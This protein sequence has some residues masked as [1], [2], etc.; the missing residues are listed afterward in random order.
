MS[1]YR[2]DIKKYTKEVVFQALMYTL[3]FFAVWHQP[4]VT[5]VANRDRG[6]P[7]ALNGAKE[8]AHLVFRPL[9]GFF[10]AIIFIHQ[11]VRNFRREDASLSFYEAL[12]IVFDREVEDPEHIVSN[13][14]L[15]K[16]DVA[17]GRLVFAFDDSSSS[18]DDDEDCLPEAIEM[19]DS[20]DGGRAF[21]CLQD[22]SVEESFRNLDGFS[23]DLSFGQDSV[24][25]D[26]SHHQLILIS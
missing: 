24:R 26:T 2:S 21:D 10:N 13:L 9:Q 12:M 20:L 25:D 23:Q 6:A 14:I 4:F 16:R 22:Q 5:A 11:K 1:T 15:V 3:V 19:A 18:S 8:I 17:L 7:Y